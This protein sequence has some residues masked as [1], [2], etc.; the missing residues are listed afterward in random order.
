MPASRRDRQR[1]GER[2]PDAWGA[3]AQDASSMGLDNLFGDGKSQARSRRCGRSLIIGLVELLK[4]TRELIGRNSRPGVVDF[5]LKAVVHPLDR[6][7]Y[8]AALWRE[9]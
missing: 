3:V 8:R 9:L 7:L 1:Y 5:D 6:E 4:D 2:C